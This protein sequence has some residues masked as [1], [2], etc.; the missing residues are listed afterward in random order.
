M[1]RRTEAARRQEGEAGCAGGRAGRSRGACKVGEGDA[2][3]LVAG[4]DAVVGFEAGGEILDAVTGARKMLVEL[5]LDKTIGL[6]GMVAIPPIEFIK[7]RT[8][9]LPYP[10]SMMAKAYVL[11][12][13][14]SRGLD[15]SKSDTLAPVRMNPGG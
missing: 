12:C 10:R 13:A 9:S 4:G 7:A 3:F 15:W 5:G 6:W 2:E 14:L 11:R 8:E 1:G